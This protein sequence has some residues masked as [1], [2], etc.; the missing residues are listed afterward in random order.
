MEKVGTVV[1]AACLAGITVVLLSGCVSNLYP[2][3]PSVAGWI[4]TGVKD[5]AQAL[6][7][8]VD[9]SA[10]SRK[11]GHSSAQAILGLVAYGDSSIDAAMKDGGITK[12][13][14]IDHMVELVFGGVWAKS[15]TIVR[16]E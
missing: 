5:P 6:T 15:T 12:V 11:Q 16:G 9:P 4:Y 7:V 3:G 1:V 13:H 10:S 8:A 14:H 2:G